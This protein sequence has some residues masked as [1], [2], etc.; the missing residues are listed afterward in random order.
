MSKPRQTAA[1]ASRKKTV[2][3]GGGEALQ[4]RFEELAMLQ[5]TVLDITAPHDLPVHL[6]DAYG[7]G[8]YLC[9][10]KRR[11]VRLEVSYK[12]LQNY[13]GTVLPYGEGAAGTTAQTGVP[14]II[15]DYRT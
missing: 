11:E 4:R 5:A 14:M 2:R 15:T 6:L 9:D 1:A 3:P 12:T 8:L 13:I 7:G 10:E